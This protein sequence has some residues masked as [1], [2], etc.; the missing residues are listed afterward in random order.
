[1]VV[2][3]DITTADTGDRTPSAKN[4][5]DWGTARKGIKLERPLVPRIKRGRLAIE[6]IF[7]G[8]DESELK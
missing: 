1:M 8:L 3:C 5:A 2:L 7:V 6:S 4:Q